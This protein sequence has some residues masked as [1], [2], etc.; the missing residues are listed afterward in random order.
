[1]LF[2]LPLLGGATAAAAGP[3]QEPP[4]LGFTIPEPRVGDRVMYETYGQDDRSRRHAQAVP[5]WVK[6]A[7]VAYEVT[8]QGVVAD[9]T[10]TLHPGFGLRTVH[11]EAGHEQGDRFEDWE[12]DTVRSDHVVRDRA[13]S[14]YSA[15]LSGR[16]VVTGAFVERALGWDAPR[17]FG[18]T[19]VFGEEV[20]IPPRILGGDPFVLAQVA[21]EDDLLWR[22]NAAHTPGRPD[23]DAYA[24]RAFVLAAGT[25][26]DRPALGV[27]TYRGAGAMEA[28]RADVVRGDGTA[29]DGAVVE[30]HLAW[31]VPTSPYPVQV[32]RRM[33]LVEADG[34]TQ[35]LGFT[36]TT[37]ASITRGARPLTDATDDILGAIE[38]RGP[39]VDPALLERSGAQPWPADGE[40]HTLAYPLSEAIE[41]VHA[42]AGAP[43]FVVWRTEHPE[44]ALVGALMT[45][46]QHGQGGTR[47]ARWL[48][49][50]ATSDGAG[51]LVSTQRAVGQER[52]TVDDLGAFRTPPFDPAA[53]PD[54][55]I[56]L[57]EAER[58]WR[59][60]GGVPDDVRPDLVAWGFRF[61]V[62][63]GAGC[64]DSERPE[65]LLHLEEPLRELSQIQIGLTSAGRCIQTRDVHVGSSLLLDLQ[66]G[67]PLATVEHADGVHD[68]VSRWVPWR[69]HVPGVREDARTHG[70][71][72]GAFVDP[73]P[74]L[75]AATAP[76]SA[77]VA[78]SAGDT[79]AMAASTAFATL[80]ALGL[81][82]VRG[83]ALWPAFTRLRR[84]SLLDNASRDRVY[85][86]VEEDP[87]IHASALKDRLA[88]GWGTTRHHLKV[89]EAHGLVVS[90]PVGRRRAYFTTEAVPRG[91]RLAHA[92]LQNAN[93]RRVLDEVRR[94][95]GT[96]TARIAE[97][98]GLAGPT[99]GWHLRRLQEAG[100]VASEPDGRA[101]RHHP[102]EDRGA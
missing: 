60:V 25:F 41:D 93:T 59:R 37:L 8:D 85:R 12:P 98:L 29:L 86:A 32:D 74:G 7:R 68:L 34:D 6:H 71:F 56:T 77:T 97:R 83:V 82:K 61:G 13:V 81:A 14:V 62:G 4:P 67:R 101:R 28:M 11:Y 64:P 57:A 96:I 42:P 21:R 47:D 43:G 90:R 19:F 72:Y 66:T 33:V 49:L 1:M 87:G 17:F 20:G 79:V 94:A 2:A 84:S 69:Q 55:P 26:E 52:P 54:D 78:G 10:G 18:K 92:V 88:M 102:V 39:E 3:E 48:L 50:F 38:A 51:R 40:D 31:Y 5:E 24:S 53:L 76:R 22:I 9:P 75:T 30:R 16:G 36:R 58:Q 44:A 27:A 45:P 46:A 63:A 70:P 15:D 99:V 23:V 95:P 65:S 35:E 73:A 89:L 80:A 100:L 91:E